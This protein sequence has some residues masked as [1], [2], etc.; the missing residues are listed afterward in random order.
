MSSQ[1]AVYDI[2]GYGRG[3]IPVSD[4]R[5]SHVS[6]HECGD[7][8]LMAFLKGTRITG[9]QLLQAHILNRHILMRIHSRASVSGKMLSAGEDASIPGSP[10]KSRS[11]AG[12]ESG[13]V[14]VGAY[15]DYRVLRV[16]VYVEHRAI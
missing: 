7:I 12:Y 5:K 13:I 9:L 4:L 10:D 16:G 11:Q 6:G 14:S 8:R 1:N 2:S 3:N 15:V